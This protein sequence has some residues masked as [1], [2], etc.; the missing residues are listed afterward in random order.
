M[1]AMSH[2]KC[3]GVARRCLAAAWLAGCAHAALGSPSHDG[4]VPAAPE[5]RR[6]FEHPRSGL[7]FAG[8]DV[9]ALQSDDANNPGM[10][11]VE[12][13]AD[14]WRR[15][16]GASNRSCA[17]CHGQAAESMR[18]VATRL[19]AIDAR[20]GQLTNLQ[21]RI[22]ACRTQRMGATPLGYESESLLSL[23][24]WVAYQSRG[25]PIRVSI[26]GPARPHF[27]AGRQMY[28]QR[29][30]QLDLACAHCHERLAGHRLLAE[31]ISQGQPSAYPIYRLEWQTMGSLHR[32]FRSCLYGVR[33]EMLPQ[34][35]PEF[36]DLELFLAWRAQGLPIE[37]P[38][39][40]R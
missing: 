11:W 8:D 3:I 5:P 23:A 20:T 15:P 1:R 19:P 27:E 7:T 37:T 35:S 9:R 38:G 22:N 18:G 16:E 33:A 31:R 2:R 14:L 4:T 13:G 12:H 28:Y 24:A 25:L 29:M 26:D 17:D 21:G 39:V 34:G 10:L 40:R 36:I 6:V 32:R 30:G